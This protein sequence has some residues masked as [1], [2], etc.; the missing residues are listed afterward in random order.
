M[1]SNSYREQKPYDTAASAEERQFQNNL[2]PMNPEIT[3]DDHGSSSNDYQTSPSVQIGLHRSQKP[4]DQGPILD[5]QRINTS[6]SPNRSPIRQSNQ[7][8]TKNEPLVIQ[9]KAEEVSQEVATD[10]VQNLSRGSLEEI[11]QAIKARV[12]SLLNPDGTRKRKAES[13]GIVETSNPKRRV[14]CDQCSKTMVRRCDLRYS[15]S[16]KEPPVSPRPSLS[17]VQPIFYHKSP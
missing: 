11:E 9:T 15:P 4:R 8:I 5:V 7:T 10:V 6:R 2:L 16:L 14:A 12:L 17:P 13:A 3:V 1:E